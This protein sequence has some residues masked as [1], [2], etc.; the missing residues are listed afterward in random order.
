MFDRSL[1]FDD[2]ER[3]LSMF[4]RSLHFDDPEHP[5]STLDRSL[6]FHDEAKDDEIFVSKYSNSTQTHM[7]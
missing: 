3:S 5:L 1:H 6:H 2:L 7:K 4:D